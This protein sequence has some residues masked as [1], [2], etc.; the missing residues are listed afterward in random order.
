MPGRLTRLHTLNTT[1]TRQQPRPRLKPRGL[2]PALEAHEVYAAT[3]PADAALYGE[4]LLGSHRVHVAP[5][6]DHEF[7][8]TFHA[9]LIRDVTLRLPRLLHR[10]DG[11]RAPP[12]RQL[13]S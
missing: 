10:G 3:N 4:D 2:P 7:T 9:V 6:M 5:A 8:A 1:R 11:G 12:A 13:R